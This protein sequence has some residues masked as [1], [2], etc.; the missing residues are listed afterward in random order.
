[1]KKSIFI[2]V[3]CIELMFGNC[4]ASEKQRVIYIQIKKDEW[5]TFREDPF[6][7]CYDVQ[8]KFYYPKRKYTGGSDD[9]EDIMELIAT[10]ELRIFAKTHPF[11]INN[12]KKKYGDISFLSYG[13]Y[14]FYQKGSSNDN[15]KK[16]FYFDKSTYEFRYTP[17]GKEEEYNVRRNMSKYYDKYQTNDETNTTIIKNYPD[18]KS[19]SMYHRIEG[20]NC[21]FINYEYRN[22]TLEQQTIMKNIDDAYMISFDENESKILDSE[23]VH[24]KN[25]ISYIGSYFKNNGDD[26]DLLSF[27]TDEYRAR[28]R[29]AYGFALFK[30]GD[31][32]GVTKIFKYFFTN[33]TFK[34]LLSILMPNEQCLVE[35]YY[36][37]AYYRTEL[38]KRKRRQ[39][40]IQFIKNDISNS[41]SKKSEAI[42]R[43][44]AVATTFDL[45]NRNS[46]E[47][48][49]ILAPLFNKNG[50]ETET[51]KTLNDNLAIKSLVHFY[52]GYNSHFN[53]PSIFTINVLNPIL[54]DSEE[55]IHK[56]IP[57]NNLYQ[58]LKEQYKAYSLFFYI[59]SMENAGYDISDILEY[60][61]FLLESKDSDGNFYAD[62]L[63]EKYKSQ[64]IYIYS[65]ILFE[66]EEYNSMTP[67]FKF[68]F[69][70]QGEDTKN[71]SLLNKKEQII[72]RICNSML[73]LQTGM[74]DE[75]LKKI[76]LPLSTKN[77]KIML[78]Q[79]PEYYRAIAR[80]CASFS[81][82]L[83]QKYNESISMLRIWFEK[84]DNNKKLNNR[85]NRK[86]LTDERSL[87]STLSFNM[88][89]M[90]RLCYGS[91]FLLS[92]QNGKAREILE[93]FFNFDP[94]HYGEYTA[95]GNGLNL[96]LQAL[97][98]FRYSCV[99]T[100]NSLQEIGEYISIV[101]PFF[102]QDNASYTNLAL[103]LN[104]Y[105]Q[106]T[107]RFCF[108]NNTF[109]LGCP[110]ET[111]KILNI[112][113]PEQMFSEKNDKNKEDDSA[114]INK[115]EDIN[116]LDDEHQL[117]AKL[118]YAVSL[119]LINQFSNPTELSEPQSKFI[120][121]T[122]LII[123][124]LKKI[125]DLGKR[126]SEKVNVLLGCLFKPTPQILTLDLNP[127]D[128]EN[129][130]SENNKT[131][132]DSTVKIQ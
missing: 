119:R 77:G 29:F 42:S 50:I 41:L 108:A 43:C 13:D 121:L 62:F 88:Q 131:D 112:F 75:I 80:I 6:I 18:V 60:C 11:L 91:A 31:N 35:F 40:K 15:Q 36:K 69:N 57:K 72:I 37:N 102:N 27:V 20:F 73:L 63:N 68:F 61:S 59:S 109:E 122:E 98:R 17:E 94:E 70:A 114:I 52:Y 58:K 45:E 7:C 118:L 100:K 130:K 1:M 95:L 53:K 104:P 56:R 99:I 66:M 10:E 12:R 26:S 124:D 74:K 86:N 8:E 81:L 126:Y 92:N 97:A 25:I 120:K 132:S 46:T 38:S 55:I 39:N 93:A 85:K 22:G 127:Y 123:K 101:Q 23:Y 113:F 87:I 54:N 49:E 105:Y 71:L 48:I 47:L 79:L 64:Y 115:N 125:N 32:F 84:E 2:I 107:L 78:S 30:K 4:Y 128:K 106:V 51:L 117:Q 110:K 3:Q 33:Q 24:S 82:Y 14:Q 111:I 16:F 44:A 90:L 103:Q 19:L 129:E 96:E 89:S 67:F 116:L 5:P 83:E 76:I 65:R 21:F 9:Q 34:N 28:A